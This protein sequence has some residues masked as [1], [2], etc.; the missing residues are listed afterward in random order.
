MDRM[1]G[2]VIPGTASFASTLRR[3][4][5]ARRR[6]ICVMH[7]KKEKPPRADSA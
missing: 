3:T 2:V 6:P 5:A 7:H 1:Y 4:T